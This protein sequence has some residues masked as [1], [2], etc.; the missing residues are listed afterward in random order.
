MEGL[1]GEMAIT[2]MCP[3]EGIA[4][5]LYYK[6]AKEFMETGKAQLPRHG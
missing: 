4:E 2:E 3:R 6:W 5:S 1:R